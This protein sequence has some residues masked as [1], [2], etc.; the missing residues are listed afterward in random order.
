[1]QFLPRPSQELAI[2]RMLDCDYQLLALRMG[3]GKTGV[4]L[5]VINELLFN[6][7]EVQRVLVVAPLRVAQLVWHTEAAKWDHTRHL[8]VVKVLGD[9]MTRIRALAAPGDVYVVNRENFIW[10]VKLMMASKG[11]WP[12]DCVIVDENKGFKDRNSE[13]WKHLMKVRSHIDKLYLL[14]GTPAPNTL[15]ELWPQIT[16]MDEGERLGRRLTAY[17]ERYFA[18]DKRNGN[19]IYSWRLKQG[20]EKLIYKAVEDV[21]LS[22]ESGVELPERIDN[23]IEVEFDMQRYL[24]M[25]QTFVSGAVSAPNAAVLAGKLRQ[26]ANG[27]VYDDQRY[28][29][30]IHDAKLDAL[31]EIVDQGEPV[32][33]FTEYQHDQARII[34][35]FPQAVVFDGE[36]SMAN[37]KAGKIK[38]MLMHPQSGG[39][40]VDGL[41]FG[42]NVIVW[43]ALPFSLDA[44]EQATARIHRSGQDKNVTVH[45]I[46]AKRT[47]DE[48]IMQV[49]AMKG[50]AQQELLDAVLIEAVNDAKARVTA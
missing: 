27:A 22:V 2:N 42:G 13:S 50:K 47:I 46:V 43:F 19:I 29:H 3:A 12:F 45:H 40:G 23:V 24:Q 17:R 20:A 9:Q 39:H 41:Q 21:M 25:E 37:W 15:L 5:T 34:D 11:G 36:K 10:L 31:E 35:R 16:M 18:P 44:Y 48:K 49:L 30:W 38:L 28:P 26:M 32:L 1:M 8:R 14:T 4:A 7:F 6:R 33:C